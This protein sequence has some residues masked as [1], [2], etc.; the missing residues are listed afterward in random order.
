MARLEPK[1]MPAQLIF[2]HPAP[3]T[4]G[5]SL[6][7]SK[8]A[9]V[10]RVKSN[11]P[12][13]DV[14]KSGDELVT[15]DDQAIVSQADVQ[16]VLHHAEAVDELPMQIR[17]DGELL[18]ATLRL[19][20]RWRFNSDISWRTAGWEMRRMALGGL[21]LVSAS[22][23]LRRKTSLNQN[24][25]ALVVDYVGQYVEFG[26]AKKVG[27]KKGDVIVKYGPLSHNITESQ[28]LAW[29]VLNTRPGQSVA[30]TFVRDGERMTLQMPMQR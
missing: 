29:S 5:F 10:T 4:V 2:P 12:A 1:P 11:S 25:L 20:E 8:R 3:S 24:E 23:A 26:T 18:A 19:P 22:D 9:A 6:D 21:K 27:F 16:W 28:L 30:V 17:R 7:P 14:L 13:G 15:L